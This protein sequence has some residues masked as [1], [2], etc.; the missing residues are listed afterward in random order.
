MIEPQ[1]ALELLLEM[2]CAL[3]P[4]A[5]LVE[6]LPVVPELAMRVLAGDH[7]SIRVV[8]VGSQRVLC[9]VRAGEGLFRQPVPFAPGEGVLGWVI[10]NRAPARVEDTATDPRFVEKGSQGFGIGS[11]V[12]APLWSGDEVIGVLSV[13]GKATHVFYDWDLWMLELIAN[14]ASPYLERLRR[15]LL[16]A[17]TRP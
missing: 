17:E 12:A 11:L 13:S 4:R 8:D 16:A 15:E 14:T 3:R 2:T 9:R 10:A 1:R 5:G 6:Q 7:A